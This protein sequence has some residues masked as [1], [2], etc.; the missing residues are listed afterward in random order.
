VLLSQ[1]AAALDVRERVGDGDPDVA[2]VTHDSRRVTA[3]ALFCCVR[4]ASVDG[5][6]FAST[7]VDAG[8]VALLCERV[9]PLD[10]PQVV[11]PD[12]RRGAA[13][14]A[15]ACWGYPATSLR[16]VGVTGT[17]GK[18]TTVSMVEQM[19]NANSVRATSIG[20]L[21]SVPGA[22]PTTPD[23][24][25]LQR[26]LAALRDGAYDAVA[27]EVSSHALVSN[28][29]DAITFDVAVFT[30]LSHEHLDFHGSMDAYFAAKASLFTPE[31][32]RVAL[33]CVDDE[34]GA[35]LAG[36]AGDSGLPIVRY[37]V[38]DAV[39]EGYDGPRT[40]GRWHGAAATLQLSGRH[41]IANAVA[42]ANVGEALGLEPQAALD[43]IASLAA[44]PGRFEYV[45]EG[46]PFSVVVDYAH[47]PAALE[48]ALEA[49]RTV[50][51]GQGRVIVVVGAGGDKDRAK[52][53]LMAAVCE[54]RAGLVVLTS[55]NPRHEDPRAILEEMQTGLRDPS[56]VI[57]DPDRAAAIAFAINA[58]QVGDVVLIA[59]KGHETTQ[60]I[61]DTVVDFDDRVVARRAIRERT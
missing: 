9:L 33:I 13:F 59:G 54:E 20:T 58:A 57:I 34:W 47:T 45:D 56:R 17:N 3:G 36:V 39:V 43:G 50:V 41:N 46:Q 16:M 37:S 32:T 25:D 51:T 8:A 15:A 27:M 53:P 40:T 18:T 10:V 31:R 30:N 2:D 38:Q 22:P 24:T 14:A 49:A 29:V 42:A 4:G 60:T 44:V 35:R 5:H 21:H 19:L 26:H 12:A 1:I 61:G 11:V 28:R 23:A 52:R 7:A 48:V 55:D 6:E